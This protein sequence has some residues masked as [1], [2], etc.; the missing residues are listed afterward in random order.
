MNRV[1]NDSIHNELTVNISGIL[2]MRYEHDPTVAVW[3]V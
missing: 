3:S 1:S 2:K